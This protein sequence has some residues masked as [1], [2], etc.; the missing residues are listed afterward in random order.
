MDEKINNISLLELGNGS[1]MERADLEFKKILDNIKDVNTNPT[2]KRTLVLTIDFT[3]SQD[4]D[5]LAVK[6][7]AKSKIEPYNP[8][9]TGLVLQGDKANLKAYELVPNIP[10]QIGFN[11]FEQKQPKELRILLNT[12][13]KGDKLN[14]K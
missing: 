7:S 1:F 14:V 5:K 6:F 8:V 2:K 13:D 4:R 10:G 3:P 12:N 9:E 11:G